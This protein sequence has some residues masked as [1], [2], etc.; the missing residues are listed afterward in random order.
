MV[1]GA[2]AQLP[3]MMTGTLNRLNSYADEQNPVMGKDGKILFF[4]RA[5]HAFDVGGRADKGDIWISVYN[6]T[7]GWSRPENVGRELN[8]RYQNGVIGQTD[9]GRVFL[10]GVYHPD[11]R[12]LSAGV[13][14]SR[15][16]NGS[17][18]APVSESVKYFSNR[19]VNQGI[20]ISQDGSIMLL[21]LESFKTYGAEDIYVSFWD[22][23]E[24]SWTEPKNLGPVINTSLQELSPFLTEDKKTLYFSSNGHG[25]YGSRDIF[26]STRLDDS[27]TNWS[28]PLNLGDSINSSG[29]EMYFS[30]SKSHRVAIFTSTKDSDGYGDIH[31]VAFSPDNLPVHINDTTTKPVIIP[32]QDLNTSFTVVVRGAIVDA[33][34]GDSVSAKIMVTDGSGFQREHFN[35]NQFVFNLPT[36]HQ[37]SL[38][39][40]AEGYVSKNIRLDLQTN[41]LRSLYKNIVLDPIQVGTTVRLENV[42]F[43]R[44]TTVFLDQS[45]DELDLI[46]Q[47]M[48]DNPTMEIE[49]AGHTD[50]VGN[51]KLNLELSQKR[52]EAVIAYLKQRGILSERLSGRG[53]GGS[54]PIASNKTEKTRRLNRR[55]EFIIKKR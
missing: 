43:K 48:K 1:S 25:G 36:A 2:L 23:V 27:W 18:S 12:P 54:N 32:V 21:S 8:N 51:P 9:D 45:F 11:N 37:Y 28:T 41:E 17:W 10:Y 31:I 3:P 38:N 42:L 47:M 22:P 52:V 4:K 50:N 15:Y 6:D 49:L 39:V 5:H 26:R 16:R 34:S 35:D 55:V 14:R 46:A 7:T 19:S 29:A 24:Q 30:V 53:Y 20:S 44:G 13:S 33:I 40:E